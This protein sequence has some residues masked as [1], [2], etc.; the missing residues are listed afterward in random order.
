MVT[1]C[2]FKDRQTNNKQG[3]TALRLHYTDISIQSDNQTTMQQTDILTTN[4][5]TDRLLINNDKLSIN[6]AD[7]QKDRLKPVNKRQKAETA[8]EQCFLCPRNMTLI[9]LI[10]YVH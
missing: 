6:C 10:H 1:H 5:Q 4:L 8:K 3:Q 7:M 9:C 2:S